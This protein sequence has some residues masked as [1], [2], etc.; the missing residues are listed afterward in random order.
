MAEK[1]GSIGMPSNN[2][3]G[4]VMGPSDND[5][6]GDH[7]H[8][9]KAAAASG[10]RNNFPNLNSALQGLIGGSDTISNN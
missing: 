10:S 6:G 1:R 5:Y 4:I 2:P 9:N 3:L 8:R 7:L